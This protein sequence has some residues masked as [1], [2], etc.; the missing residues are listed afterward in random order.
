MLVIDASVIVKIYAEETNPMQY[1]HLL[2][3]N[4]RSSARLT[5]SPKSAKPSPERFAE[6]N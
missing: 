6:A 1:S 3:K 4:I 5:L 2:S